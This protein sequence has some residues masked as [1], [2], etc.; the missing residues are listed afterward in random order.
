MSAMEIRQKE[1]RD[2]PVTVELS[3]NSPELEAHKALANEG[4][5]TLYIYGEDKEVRLWKK[6]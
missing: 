5:I 3:W 1:I 2:N 4:R 6:E